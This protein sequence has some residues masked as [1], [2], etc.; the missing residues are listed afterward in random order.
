MRRTALARLVFALS[1]FAGIGVWVA[2]GGSDDQDVTSPDAGIDSARPVEEED[3]YTPPRDSGPNDSGPTQ[4]QDPYADSGAPIVIYPDGGEF[5]D[6]GIECFEGGE[7]EVEPNNN[8]PT[9]TEFP[10]GVV[11]SKFV[12][13]VLCGAIK[14]GDA[15]F[16]AGEADW[17]KFQLSD[18]S[19]GFYVKYHGKLKVNVETD[20]RAPVDITVPDASLG[21]HK[22]GQTYYVEVRSAD[23]TSQPWQII[24]FENR[25][26]P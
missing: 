15:G 22:F 2:C 18:A 14:G 1:A 6:A 16:D 17:L 9:A 20:G 7:I 8:K 10:D 13:R 3:A 21:V 25:P 23:G 4:P 19:T 11:E 12:R 24:V 26:A 5:A